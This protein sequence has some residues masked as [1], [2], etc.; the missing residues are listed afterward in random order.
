VDGK[1]I[2]VTGDCEG[3]RRVLLQIAATP[4]RYAA[5]AVSSPVT[6]L[7]EAGG[8]PVRLL[9]QMGNVPIF[10][11]H[12]TEDRVSPVENSRRFYAESQKLNMPVE[13]VEVKGSHASLSKDNHRYLFEFFSRMELKQE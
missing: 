1:K 13:Y 4:E 3:G 11:E 12:G 8:I 2:F 10:I 7:G 6:A 5:C 9:S